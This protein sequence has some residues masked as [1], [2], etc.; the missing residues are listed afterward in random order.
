MNRRFNLNERKARQQKAARSSGRISSPE[1]KWKRPDS[2]QVLF[3]AWD[4]SEKYGKKYGFAW[5]SKDNDSRFEWILLHYPIRKIFEP[6]VFLH[7]SSLNPGKMTS[8]TWDKLRLVLLEEFDKDTDGISQQELWQRDLVIMQMLG[9]LQLNLSYE[10]IVTEITTVRSG[11]WNVT[12]S[13]RTRI[14]SKRTRSS[15]NYASQGLLVGADCTMMMIN[16]RQENHA[17]RV[18]DRTTLNLLTQRNWRTHRTLPGSCR[19]V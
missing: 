8:P 14:W 2:D 16:H 11:A 19:T 9:Q 5:R 3:I 15:T 12:W 1:P 10:L 18:Q 4:K 6:P 17:H 13:K 7:Q